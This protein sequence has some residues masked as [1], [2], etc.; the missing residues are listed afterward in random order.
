MNDAR[1][2]HLIEDREH[3]ANLVASAKALG[4]T[5]TPWHHQRLRKLFVHTTPCE[6]GID[7]NGRIVLTDDDEMLFNLKMI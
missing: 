6:F 4:L 3:L 1:P 7:E 2:L 5:K